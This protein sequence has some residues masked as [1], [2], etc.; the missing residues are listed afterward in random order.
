MHRARAALPALVVLVLAG[1]APARLVPAPGTVA[2]PGPGAGAIAEAAGVRVV[3]RT[4]A[5][6]GIPAGLEFAVIPVLVMVENNGT[7]ALRVRHDDFALVGAGDRRYTALS[8]FEIRGT[9]AVPVDVPYPALYPRPYPP[10]HSRWYWDDPFW[11]P[12]YYPAFIYVPLPTGD[13]IQKAL[14]ETT[15]EPGGRVT[16]FVYFPRVRKKDDPAVTF[17]ATIVDAR[18][19][20]VLGTA[21]IPFVY[22]E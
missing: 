14:P 19:S 1:C 22:S 20:S 17:T 5:W 10:F 3:A 13:M 7:H 2:V 21:S 4:G 16:G 12:S 11:Y 18:T 6:N 8:P 15:V 9:V